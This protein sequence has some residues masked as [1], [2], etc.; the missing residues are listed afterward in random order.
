ME[1]VPR[2][3]SVRDKLPGWTARQLRKLVE[4]EKLP[5]A[6]SLFQTLGFWRL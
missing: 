2:A 6:R 4:E 3:L 5:Q 1:M